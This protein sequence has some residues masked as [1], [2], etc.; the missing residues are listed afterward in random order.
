MEV[1]GCHLDIR[2]KSVLVE[3]HCASSVVGPV[4]PDREKLVLNILNCFLQ[5]DDAFSS[6]SRSWIPVVDGQSFLYSGAVGQAVV[7]VILLRRDVTSSSGC[8]AEL[9]TCLS[10]VDRVTFR[11]SVEIRFQPRSKTILYE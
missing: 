3:E 1:D 11:K 8:F 5:C 6:T 7:E 4:E 2:K 9:C 10:N